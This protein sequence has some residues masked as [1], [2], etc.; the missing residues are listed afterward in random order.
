MFGCVLAILAMNNSYY[1]SPFQTSYISTTSLPGFICDVPGIDGHVLVPPY[2][3]QVVCFQRFDIAPMGLLA[4]NNVQ[5]GNDL[6]G[7]G[8]KTKQVGDLRKLAH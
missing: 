6:E 1:M 7:A 4:I 2:M 8:A 3:S 5:N